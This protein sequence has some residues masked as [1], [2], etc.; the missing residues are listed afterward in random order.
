MIPRQSVYD[1][2]DSERDYQDGR[3]GP[4]KHEMGSFL[5]Y[6]QDYMDE[7]RR[8]LSRNPDVQAVPLA[9]MT[10]RKI[11]ALGVACMEQHGAPKRP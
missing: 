1:A 7:A 6:M 10:L 9:L 2:I 4:A 5:L 3:W 8:Q 11:V